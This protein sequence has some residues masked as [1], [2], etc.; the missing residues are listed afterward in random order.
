MRVRKYSE[1]MGMIPGD[2]PE[3]ATLVEN[4]RKTTALCDYCWITFVGLAFGSFITTMVTSGSRDQARA[5]L[6]E[7]LLLCI[8][9]DEKIRLA[10][11]SGLQDEKVAKF[12]PDRDP[13]EFSVGVREMSYGMSTIGLEVVKDILL[14]LP[15]G[16]LNMHQFITLVVGA[17]RFLPPDTSKQVMAEILAIHEENFDQLLEMLED[18]ALKDGATLDAAE[19]WT[20]MVE[21]WIAS[22]NF[23]DVEILNNNELLRRVTERFGGPWVVPAEKYL[24]N[25]PVE[26]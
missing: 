3:V 12:G 24:E 7:L 22:E 11:R 16:L 23:M 26:W 20:A 17:T 4:I 19:K 1:V 18:K 9:S 21:E 13:G 10:I 6:H 5:V 14:T 15:W 25:A 2:D 8:D